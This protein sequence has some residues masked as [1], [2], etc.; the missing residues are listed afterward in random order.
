MIQLSDN[1]LKDLSVITGTLV[2]AF[3]LFCKFDVLEIIVEFSRQHE[4]YE[5]DELLATLVIFALCMLIFSW[6]RLKETD[7]ARLSAEERQ[8]QLEQALTEVKTLQGILPICSYCNKIRDEQGRWRELQQY[9]KSHLDAEFSHGSCPDCFDIRMREL[10]ET[11]G[12]Q[13][14]AHLVSPKMG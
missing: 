13:E 5:I 10:K 4:A 6:R 12:T 1:V 7:L 2:A 9:I 3:L 14:T 8:S 11:K